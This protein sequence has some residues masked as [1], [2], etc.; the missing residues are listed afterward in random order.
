M[1][2]QENQFF[3]VC[4]VWFRHSFTTK[5]QRVF[6]RLILNKTLRK[7]AIQMRYFFFL[8]FAAAFT[9]QGYAQRPDTLL[10]KL[11]SLSQQPDSAGGQVNRTDPEAYNKDTRIPIPGFFIPQCA[12]S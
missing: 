2:R 4:V 6:G 11:D 3:F 12:S 8:F 10:R 7:S 5:S 9:C 1:Y